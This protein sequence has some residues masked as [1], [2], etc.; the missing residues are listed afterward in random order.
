MTEIFFGDAVWYYRR[1]ELCHATIVGSGHGYFHLSNGD[2]RRNNELIFEN[3][4]V[5]PVQVSLN[6]QDFAA[7]QTLLCLSR[8]S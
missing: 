8:S 5:T 2:H 6:P 4:A 3:P 1:G 7:V